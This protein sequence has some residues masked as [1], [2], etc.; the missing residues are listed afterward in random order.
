MVSPETLIETSYRFEAICR[1]TDEAHVRALV[2]QAATASHFHLRAVRSEDLDVGLDRVR[3]TAVLEGST[4]VTSKHGI[5]RHAPVRRGGTPIDGNFRT[6]GWAR[7]TGHLP[8][9]ASANAAVRA[10]M[11]V[12]KAGAAGLA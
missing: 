7:D 3:V 5:T 4:A 11:A 8:S 6:E 10:A 2:T 12:E 1:A 9:S